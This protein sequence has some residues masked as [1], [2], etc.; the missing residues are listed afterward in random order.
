MG[1]TTAKIWC[2]TW[3]G[4]IAHAFTSE[5]RALCRSSIRPLDF[6]RTGNPP[7][8]AKPVATGPYA[9]VCTRCEAK[10][11]EMEAGEK[12]ALESAPAKVASPAPVEIRRGDLVLIELRPSYTLS[13]MYARVREVSRTALAPTR[14][15]LRPSPSDP[16]GAPCPRFTGSR[17][18]HHVLRRPEKE[19]TMPIPYYA[20]RAPY[21]LVVVHALTGEYRAREFASARDVEAKFMEI[22]T[23]QG[24]RKPYAELPFGVPFSYGYGFGDYR[25][26]AV[27]KYSY[28]YWNAYPATTTLR[29]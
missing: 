13:V 12:V 19:T 26:F 23:A 22:L 5:H 4:T 8:R 7:Y 24:W 25:Y 15:R 27:T 11:A 28:N 14:N 1:I 16:F 10:V 3:T 6:E 9:S 2:S 17:A 29:P 18:G 21:K 20:G